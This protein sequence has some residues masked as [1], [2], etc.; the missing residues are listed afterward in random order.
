MTR[1]GHTKCWGQNDFGQLGNGTTLASA[2]PTEVKIPQVTRLIAGSKHTCAQ[3][4]DKSVRCWGALHYVGVA[5]TEDAK[6]PVVV[7]ALNKV[8]SLAAGHFHTCALSDGNVA[9]WGENGSGQLGRPVSGLVDEPHPVVGLPGPASS[10]FAFGWSTCANVGSDVYCWGR[11]NAG[12]PNPIPTKVPSVTAPVRAMAGSLHTCVVTDVGRVL[13]WGDNQSGQT[14][15]MDASVDS[16]IDVSTW[17]S[18]TQSIAAGHL[19]TCALTELGSVWCWGR[20]TEF[21]FSSKHARAIHIEPVRL[22]F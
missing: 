6:E 10:L 12:S 20:N 9:C 18:A 8:S 3:L 2:S 11:T 1:S 16:I 21:P 19:H 17:P 4:P 14:G 13:C 5:L 7:T 15:T 22:E